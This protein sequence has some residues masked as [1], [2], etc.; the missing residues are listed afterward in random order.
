MGSL[1]LVLLSGRTLNNLNLSLN[2]V[3]IDNLCPM[4]LLFLTKQF[5][6]PFVPRPDF[7]ILSYLYE[8]MLLIVNVEYTDLNTYLEI[9]PSLCKQNYNFLVL[10]NFFPS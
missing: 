9:R 7:H 3:C 4:P 6:Q 2:Y 1:I 8:E 10:Y 5:L